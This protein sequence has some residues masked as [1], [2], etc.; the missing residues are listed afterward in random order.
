MAD[1]AK[2]YQL[3]YHG[4]LELPFIELGKELHPLVTAARKQ[5]DCAIPEAW[6]KTIDRRAAIHI[7]KAAVVAN[8]FQSEAGDKQPVALS[9]REREVLIDLYHGL[10]REEIAVNRYLSINTVKKTLQSIYIKLDAN[11]NVDAVR[12]ALEKKLIE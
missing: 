1:F 4:I 8:A 6:L 11:N 9:D 7:K 12:I 2:A 5:T 3:S 10:S